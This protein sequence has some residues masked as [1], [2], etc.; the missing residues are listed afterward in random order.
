MRSRPRAMPPWGGV[1]YCRASR[2]KPNRSL[3]SSSESESS[4]KMRAWSV[5]VVDPQAS[6]ADLRAVQDEVVGLGSDRPG[7]RLEERQVLVHRGGEGVVERRPTL[8]RRLVRH[9]REVGHPE[10]AVRLLLHQPEVS[11]QLE[12]EDAHGHPQ[13]AGESTP[14]SRMSSFAAPTFSAIFRATASEAPFFARLEIP[15]RRRGG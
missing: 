7:I 6:A 4:R 15:R 1:P 10:E 2:R 13:R 9:E 14:T 3:A 5:G 11:A 12:P 8:L